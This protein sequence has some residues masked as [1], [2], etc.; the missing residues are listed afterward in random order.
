M[1]DSW[2]HRNF[3]SY[4]DNTLNNVSINNN[5][6]TNTPDLIKFSVVIA[7]LCDFLR[8]IKQRN[9]AEEHDE[10]RIADNR[11]PVRSGP[12]LIIVSLKKNDS[13]TGEVE[14]EY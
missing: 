2:C 8:P 10:N 11:G 13:H 7:S 4:N 9:S 6:T 1:T 12:I 14:N 3:F 5:K